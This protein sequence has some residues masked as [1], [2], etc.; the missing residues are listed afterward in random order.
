MVGGFYVV[1]DMLPQPNWPEDHPA[2]V[3]KLIQTLV[4]HP[5]LHVTTLDGSTGI[6]IATQVR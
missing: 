2:K 5:D 3:A 4:S 6:I 1:D